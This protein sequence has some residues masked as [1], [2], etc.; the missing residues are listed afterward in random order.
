MATIQT[1]RSARR[2]EHLVEHPGHDARAK[3]DTGSG[4]YAWLARVG[5]LAKAVSFAIVGILAIEVALGKG[6]K[7]TSRQGAL[8][9]LAHHTFGTVLL[10]L[11]AIGFAGYAIWR[12]VQAFAEEEDEGGEKGT[13]K[14]WGKRAGYVGRGLIYAGLTFTTVKI[15]TGSG[16]QQSQNQSAHKTAAAI[17]GWPAGRWIV[18]IVGVCIVGAGLWNAYRAV[19]KKFEDRWRTG[20]MSETER[21]WGGRVGVA[22][23]FA[24]AIVFSLIGV[25][26]TKAAIDYNPKDAIGF[27]GALQKLADAS[28]GPYILGVTAAGLICYALYCLVD[29]RYRDVSTNG[30]S[31]G[32]AHGGPRPRRA[33][34]RS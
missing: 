13:A 11:L 28:Y 10:V 7:A 24:R 22:G 26:V 27:D 8:Q 15:L 20:E 19:T 34:A 25:F 3:A 1:R 18:G 21:T 17:L 5:L 30:A 12:F 32:G 33:P 29:A 2:A 9:T 31:G 4:W 6:G 14:K 23:H 16:G